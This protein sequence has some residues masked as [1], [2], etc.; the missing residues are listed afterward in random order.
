MTKTIETAFVTFMMMAATLL[1]LLM[2]TPAHA[3]PL[4]EAQLRDK[5]DYI[6]EASSV[7]PVGKRMER[8]CRAE[9]RAKLLQQQASQQKAQAQGKLAEKK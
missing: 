8:E 4:S 5:L 9:W 6:C 2:A 1:A 3:R 7:D